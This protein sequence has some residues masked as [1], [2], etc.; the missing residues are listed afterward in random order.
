MDK[1]DFLAAGAVG[2]LLPMRAQAAASLSGPGLVTVA[3]AIPRSNR[4]GG[5][6]KYR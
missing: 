5:R 3:G 4:I 6:P 1:R 2:V